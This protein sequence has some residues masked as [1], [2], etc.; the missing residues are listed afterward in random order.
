MAG[1]RDVNWAFE[2]PVEFGA[3]LDRSDATFGE[4]LTSDAFKDM[5]QAADGNL[6]AFFSRPVAAA[7]GV[8]AI[9]L[10]IV[11]AVLWAVRGRRG[12]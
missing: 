5:G 2:G 3:T 1:N 12:R 11:P 10:W 4:L 6:L 7:L 8:V 9:G